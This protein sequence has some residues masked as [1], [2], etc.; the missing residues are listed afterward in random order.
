MRRFSD[1]AKRQATDNVKKQTVLAR[2]RVLNR[3]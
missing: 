2:I 3:L 1:W